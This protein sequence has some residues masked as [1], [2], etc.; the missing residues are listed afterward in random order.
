MKRIKAR[1]IRQC[2]PLLAAPTDAL[3]IVRSGAL[4]FSASNLSMIILRDR[5]F[6]IVPTGADGILSTIIR[7]LIKT[8]EDNVNVNNRDNIDE[9][10]VKSG[11]DRLP[12]ELRALEA[13]L[14]TVVQQMEEE[15]S[16]MKA[17]MNNALKLLR[18]TPSDAEAQTKIFLTSGTLNMFEQRANATVDVLENVLQ[19]SEDMAHM[20]LSKVVVQLPA[21]PT[22]TTRNRSTSGGTPGNAVHEYIVEKDVELLLENYLSDAKSLARRSQGLAWKLTST[23]RIIEIELAASRNLLLRYELR[24]SLISTVTAIFAMF[25]SL[26]G[27]N[28]KTMIPTEQESGIFWTLFSVSIGC[29][30]VVPVTL[31]MRCS[32]FF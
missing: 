7:K 28:L 25:A 21:S 18:T 24:L 30:L 17:S 9:E 23:S 6:F 1:D 8:E 12:F 26:F 29:L 15:L 20:T 2:D 13:I 19:Q 3:F 11:E 10:E 16:E 27:M 32:K 22:M 5:C 14:A 4:I 31:S